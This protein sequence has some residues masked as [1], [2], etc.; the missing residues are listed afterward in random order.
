[1]KNKIINILLFSCVLLFVWSCKKDENKIYLEGGT[2]PVLTA[3]KTGTIPL[4]FN[5]KDQQAVKF[6]WSNP[7]YQFT[8]GPSS[9]DVTYQLEIDSAGK[10]FSSAKKKV[11]TVSNDLELSMTQSQFND[12]L[13]NT[14]ELKPDVAQSIEIRLKS[15]MGS[16]AAPLYSNELKYT[17][18]PYSI[19][20]KVAPPA[21][22]KLFITGSATDKGWMGGGDAEVAAQKFTQVSTTVYELSSVH[23]KGG[24]SYL[25]V[26]VYGDW[27]NK[28]GGT[29]SGNTNNV[30]GD[31]F[32]P[33][34]SDLLA[35]ANDGD[36]K[37]VVDFQKGKFTVTK[38]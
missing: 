16:G 4:T 17:I 23:L 22:G 20:P 11:V 35:P 27:N 2:A 9:Q 34:G 29:G 24:G 25:F 30:N 1:M 6:T 7:N 37:I 31:E 10:K 26:P 3:T 19:P 5:T 12:Y 33:G 38:L 13:L 21:S 28:Y 14:L 18:T 15:Y 32:K 36:Y 8:T